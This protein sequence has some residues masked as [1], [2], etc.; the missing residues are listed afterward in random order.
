[1]PGVSGHRG[2]IGRLSSLLTKSEPLLLPNRAPQISVLILILRQETEIAEIVEKGGGPEG[3][4]SQD[5]CL[6]SYF[7]GKHILWALRECPLC[8]VTITTH[9][10][11]SLCTNHPLLTE[12]EQLFTCIIHKPKAIRLFCLCK[13]KGSC[14]IHTEASPTHLPSPL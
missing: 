3:G 5:T 14:S 13:G 8:A 4:F 6:L 2:K 9:Q 12:F 10:R 11:F 7:P 1:M